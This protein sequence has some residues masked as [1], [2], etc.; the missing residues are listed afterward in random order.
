[1]S[2]LP[3]RRRSSPFLIGLFVLS[4]IA[5]VVAGIFW[6][7]A[8]KFFQEYRYFVTYFESSVS[9]VEKGQ[10]VK[11]QG[12]PIGN[13]NSVKLAP[14][15]KLIEITMQIDRKMTVNDDICVRIEMA[16]LAGG[17]FL[18]LY[19]PDNPNEFSTVPRLSFTPKFP[20]IRSTPSTLDAM[21]LSI[22]EVMT[23]LLAIDT[24][25]IS[26][27]SIRFMHNA[28]E[29][30]GDPRLKQMIRDI[31]E[32]SRSIGNLTNKA[33][34]SNI[35]ENFSIVSEN[36]IQT[37]DKF[38]TAAESLNSQIQQLQLQTKA[39]NAYKRYDS[40][41]QTAENAINSISLNSQRVLF[42][43]QQT[44]ED[45]GTTNRQLRKFVRSVNDNASQVL[46]SEP[47]P[48]EK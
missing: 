37:T 3:S 4:G 12:V 14:D 44:I 7:G 32:T 31:D 41:M 29:L 27:E 23:N 1:M 45:L 18:Q 16:G 40:V 46:L 48:R 5:L 6:L 43:L 20:V 19:Y 35:I 34:E 39:D 17:K 8:S 2:N 30:L 47:P 22:D 26:S 21:K 10:P 11:Y 36:L 38:Q 24:K 33:N 9:G 28:A 15:G 25:N 42:T 13:V